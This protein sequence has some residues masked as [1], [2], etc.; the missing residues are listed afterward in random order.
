MGQP[1]SFASLEG[2][3]G[4]VAPR[5]GRGKR[6]AD[7]LLES[8]RR[9]LRHRQF[10]AMTVDD[11]CTGAGVT[12]G[13]FYRR[14]DSKATFF[15]ALQALALS[16]G[17]L[18]MAKIFETMDTHTLS[19]EEA[20]PRIVRALR[21]WYCRHEGTIRASITQR[22]ADPQIWEPVKALGRE[23]VEKITP[24]IF[25]LIDVSS[26]SDARL[27]VAF[28][29]QMVFSTMVNAIANNP[30]PLGLREKQLD[31]ELSRVLIAYLGTIG[32]G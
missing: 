28:A 6:T 23:Y 22:S 12:T 14:F 13:A 18:A 31:N 24:R 32:N 21:L 1:R 16:D 2:T 19:L 29:F 10:D 8:G 30:G 27:R 15:L 17:H 9:I 26:S 7:A 11:L 20:M 4:F 25:A 3:V 5:Y